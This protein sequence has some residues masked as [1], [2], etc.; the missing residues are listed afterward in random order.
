MSR[1]QIRISIDDALWDAVQAAA[2]VRR[3]A[4]HLY[5]EEILIAALGPSSMM[6]ELVEL[7]DAIRQHAHDIRASSTETRD[8][9]HV[10]A[11]YIVDLYRS[12]DEGEA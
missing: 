9:I 2:K 4:P 7:T 6:Q 5:V 8:Q 11:D 1:R 10:I 3:I 12:R